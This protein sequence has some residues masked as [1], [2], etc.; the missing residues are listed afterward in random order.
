MYLVVCCNLTWMMVN[1]GVAG[2]GE[3]TFYRV[4]SD[5]DLWARWKQSVAS[6]G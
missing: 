4:V 6:A 2:I 5:A 3:S 1:A